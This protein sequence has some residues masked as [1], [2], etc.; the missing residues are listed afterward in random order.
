MLD[1]LDTAVIELDEKNRILLMNGAAE[2]CLATGRERA[3]GQAFGTF[4]PVPEDLQLAVSA[5]RNDKLRRHLRECHLAGG[6]YD[7]NIQ[8]L[9]GAHILL[10]FYDMQWE[11]Q[12][13]Q[14][15]QRE[16]QTGMLDLLRR[17]LGHELRNP[18]GGIRGAA[19]MMAAE[20]GEQELGT[21]AR[22]IMREV[23]RIDEL[24]RRFGNPRLET[25][26]A[27]MHQ[28]I[29]EAIELMDAESRGK[30]EFQRD[31]D[32]SIPALPGDA[33]ALRQL[34]L[35]LVRNAFQA[36]ARNILLRTRIELGASLLQP[37]QTMQFRLDVEDDGAGVPENLR[38][39]LFLPLVTGRRDGTGLGLALS[40]QIAAAHGGVLSFEALAAGSRF[41]LRLPLNGPGEEHRDD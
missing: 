39:L 12:R 29:D 30:L 11:Q 10:E 26:E 6:L 3:S 5:T 13:H 23:D 7:C 1:T 2:Q 20:L 14:L 27:D 34:V 8:S 24:I 41:T 17:H 16:V 15:E 18:L 19:Q 33:S 31:Y 40:Q 36:G 37:G 21:L 25:S 32:P 9:P 4:Q 28:V 35:N 38:A 22:L